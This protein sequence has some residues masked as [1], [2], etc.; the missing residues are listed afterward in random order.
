MSN[1]L[2]I[3]MMAHNANSPLSLSLSLSL[4]VFCLDRGCSYFAQGMSIECRLQHR[5]L[6]KFIIMLHYADGSLECVFLCTCQLPVEFNGCEY[7]PAHEILRLINV[8]G[9]GWG[10]GWY[11]LFIKK[12]SPLFISLKFW[13][14]H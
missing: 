10:G 5:V 8:R 14:I 1:I 9:S 13:V 7:V 6:F 4:S 12:F 3:C 2:K 11:S